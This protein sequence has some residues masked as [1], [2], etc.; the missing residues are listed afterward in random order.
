MKICQLFISPGHN[1]FGHRGQPPGKHPLIEVQE[2]EC[3]TGRGIRGDR[4]FDFQKDYKGQITFFSQEVFVALC[5]SLNVMGKSPSLAR[6][7][8]L[9]EGVNLNALVGKDFELQGVKFCG[10][11]ECSPCYWMDQMYGP[12]AEH[13]LQGRG[14]LRARILMDGIL[15]VER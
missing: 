12:G 10:T 1:F 4:F 13:F 15:R 6:R 8:V 7:N 5:S 2:I 14:G 9:V 11:A 3:V